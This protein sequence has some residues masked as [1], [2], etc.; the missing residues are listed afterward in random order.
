MTDR[1]ATLR[2]RLDERR[3]VLIAAAFSAVLHLLML[4]SLPLILTPDSGEYIRTALNVGHEGGRWSV[5]NR[6]PGYQLLLYA[7]FAV[8]GVGAGGILV[9]QNVIAVGTCALITWTA[10]RLATPAI[11]L[12]VGLLYALEP[13][14]LAFANYALTETSTIFCVVLAATL[15]VGLRRATVPSAIALGIAIAVASLMRPAIL[16]MVAFFGVAWLLGCAVTMRRRA[17]LAVALALTFAISVTPWLAYNASRGIHGFASGSGWILWYGVTI[18]GFLDRDYPIDART[19]EIADKHLANGVGDWPITRVIQ[20]SGAIESVEQ[21]DRLGA[22]ARASIVKSPGAYVASLPHALLWQLNA[23]IP[24]TPPMYDELPYFCD[25]LTWDTHDP[26]RGPA[27]NFQNPGTLPRWWNFAISWHGG[28]MQAYMRV[29]GSGAMRGIP[30]IP[31]FLC[32][33]AGCLWALARR[34]WR[35]GFLLA[36]TLAFLAAHVALLQPLTRHALPAW[37]VW[38]LGLAYLLARVV[39]VVRE[40]RERPEALDAAESR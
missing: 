28:I 24:G 30:Q 27:P 6:T 2:F 7:I 11:G 21:G 26:P 37:T 32:T 31:L 8:F 3:A 5:P 34:E 4:G 40:R 38:Y 17:T 22:W 14:S 1:F 18:F 29:A 33:V 15:V 23:G 16:S 35:T 20:D 36:G 10:C 12:A 39:A 9:V 25:R 19:K 13:W